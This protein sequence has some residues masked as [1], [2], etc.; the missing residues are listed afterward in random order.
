MN[1]TENY[2]SNSD[3]KCRYCRKLQAG[4][5]LKGISIN[6]QIAHGMKQH[7]VTLIKQIDNFSG[8]VG[9]PPL[10]LGELKLFLKKLNKAIKQ[11]DNK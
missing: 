2:W 6:L 4:G 8:R 5:L 9:R 3:Y 7:R 10:L 11:H 1:I